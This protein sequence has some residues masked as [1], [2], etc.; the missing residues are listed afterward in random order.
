MP[1]PRVGAKT[2]SWLA[3]GVIV[4]LTVAAWRWGGLR[5][6]DAPYFTV[7]ALSLCLVA[8]GL[9]ARMRCDTGG[10][11]WRPDAFA[12]LGVLFL[13][14]LALQWMNAGR[15]LVYDATARQWTLTPPP[16]PRLPCAHERAEAAQMLHWFVPAWALGMI[17]R[18]PAIA[19]ADAGLAMRGTV[20]G[21][22]LLA[23]AGTVRFLMNA[24]AF[25]GGTPLSDAFFAS[26]AYTNHAAAYFL[27]MA[28][29][30]AGWLLRRLTARTRAGTGPGWVGLGLSVALC[31]LGAALSLSR[32][33]AILATLLLGF[34]VVYGA[35][36]VSG[37]ARPAIKLYGW[38]GAI[39]LATLLALL[40]AGLAGASIR[41]EFAFKRRPVAPLLPVSSGVNLDLSDR[42]RLWGVAW[43]VFQTEPLY[44]V[45]GWGFRH[46][47]ALHLPPAAWPYLRFNPGRAN[48]HCDPL[49]FMVEFGLIGG[50][51]LCGAVGGLCAGLT[52]NRLRRGALFVA[53]LLGLGAVGVFALIDLP[54]RCP[55]IL[56]TGTA[57]LAALPKAT[58]LKTGN[59]KCR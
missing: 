55:A 42:P 30:A 11:F 53:T 46:R 10:R 1:P 20:Y 41:R 5:R 34:L 32:T 39:A 29:V 58:G 24:S 12:I 36:R 33:G 48:V 6:A 40:I 31:L 15:A 38:L 16:W 50:G 59:G 22:G 23:L 47:A 35:K 28:A 9:S 19:S 43:R 8:Y 14:Y 26:F 13:L 2:G 49:Q 4:F 45:G 27:L 37:R 7:A 52:D 21:A 44:G 57:M 51:L 18:S 17:L 56:W 25:Y 3:W 54:L